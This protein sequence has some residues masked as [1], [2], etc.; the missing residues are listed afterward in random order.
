MVRSYMTREIGMRDPVVGRF[1]STGSGTGT[2]SVRPRLPGQQ[3]LG[4][5]TVVGLR[6]LTTVWYVTGART[7]SMRVDD[8][9][10]SRPLTS[11]AR[12]HGLRIDGT[13]WTATVTEDRYGPDRFLGARPVP[14]SDGTWFDG[15][16]AFRRPTS[17]TGS[18]ILAE[19]PGASVGALRATVVRVRFA[20]VPAAR[21]APS[22]APS[23]FLHLVK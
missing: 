11:P 16:L 18:V 6:R 17:G 10:L 20:P 5:V 14:T 21:P 22:C 2:V 23:T 15:D 12:I 4:P 3:T 9:M 13:S 7:D 8:D 1:R 19:N